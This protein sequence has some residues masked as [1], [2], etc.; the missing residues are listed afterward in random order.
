MN[1]IRRKVPAIEADIA[2]ANVV[3]P[4]PGTS[5]NST[6]PPPRKAVIR[7]S[8]SCGLP[9]ITVDRFSRSRATRGGLLIGPGSY[10][11]VSERADGLTRGGALGFSSNRSQ[12]RQRRSRARPRRASTCCQSA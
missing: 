7:K 1:W 11:A 10:L 4:T 2:L 6:F 5:V 9:R 12:R 8:I 3:L